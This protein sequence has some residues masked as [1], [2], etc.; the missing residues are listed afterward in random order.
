MAVFGNIGL[1]GSYIDG[2][3]LV[4]HTTKVILAENFIQRRFVQTNAAEISASVSDYCCRGQ[5]AG[6][7]TDKL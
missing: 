4:S 7:H 6:N 5:E 2:L 3:G 1:Q